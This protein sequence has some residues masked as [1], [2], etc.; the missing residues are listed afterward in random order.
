[1]LRGVLNRTRMVRGS[2][3]SHGSFVSSSSVGLGLLPLN[4][5]QP[6][7]VRLAELHVCHVP[8]YTYCMHMHRI[9]FM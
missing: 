6:H 3:L 2:A 4:W 9:N 7:Q 8:R 5:F 1:M